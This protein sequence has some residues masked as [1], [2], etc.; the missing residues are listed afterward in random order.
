MADLREKISYGFQFLSQVE[1]KGPGKEAGGAGGAGAE[2][3]T[4]Q[5][6]QQQPQQQAP[7]LPVPRRT[8]AEILAAK[9]VQGV[10]REEE[11]R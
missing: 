1:E 9:Y 7:P 4:H 10:E 3:Q 11:K 6:Q 2:G 5:H 8:A